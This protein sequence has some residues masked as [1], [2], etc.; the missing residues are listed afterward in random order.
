MSRPP[1]A[2]AAAA[3]V[4]RKFFYLFAG[5]RVEGDLPYRHPAI[6]AGV[7]A[8]AG[9]DVVVLVEMRIMILSGWL[10]RCARLL[11]GHRVHSLWSGPRGVLPPP[12]P[13]Y[14]LFHYIIFWFIII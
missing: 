10:R 14:V 5:L 7:G 13:S 4:E 8:L 11:S 12:G 2:G 3:K 9:D 1:L 6:V